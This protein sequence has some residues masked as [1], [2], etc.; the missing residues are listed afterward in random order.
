MQNK[1]KAPLWII[2][3]ILPR[4]KK[5]SSF[6][7]HKI[8][9]H[10]I[11]ACQA[12]TGGTWFGKLFDTCPNVK[13]LWEPDKRNW[14]PYDCMWDW[15]FDNQSE[16]NKSIFSFKPHVD[17][18]PHFK[19]GEIDTALYKMMTI[20]PV[21]SHQDFCKGDI[22]HNEFEAIQ[23]KLNAK[24]LHLI[25]HPVRWAA[26]VQK[27]GPRN[28]EKMKQALEFYTSHNIKFYETYKE[29]VWYRLIKYDDMV[30]NTEKEILTIFNFCNLK[31]PPP[32]YKY[33]QQCHLRNSRG[34]PHLHKTIMKKETV[35]NGWKTLYKNNEIIDYANHL[36]AK[37]W[38]NFY[39]PLR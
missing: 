16:L 7:G 28:N 3:K 27:W 18:K 13:Y 35:L 2:N 17:I 19:K 36:T 4:H 31:P 14:H 5:S 39:E 26:S 11:I 29:K 37:H 15:D 38:S 22:A 12:R 8:I 23:K 6:S 30:L 25:R 34:S 10:I 20:L 24:V 1:S 32:L 9:N 21:I 33:L